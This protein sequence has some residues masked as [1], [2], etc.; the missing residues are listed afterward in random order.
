MYIYN[1][2]VLGLFSVKTN[3]RGI[4]IIMVH[5][6]VYVTRYLNFYKT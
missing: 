2:S 3:K 4:N 1:Y 6:A 5:V